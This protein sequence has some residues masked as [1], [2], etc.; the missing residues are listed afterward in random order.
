MS[1]ATNVGNALI[2]SSGSAGVI[3]TINAN[4]TVISIGIAATGVLM[5]LVFH[6]WAVVDRK[7]AAKRDTTKQDK[8][9]ELEQQ[10]RNAKRD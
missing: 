8:I 10:L 3:A 2:I 4:A 9:N 6:I 7:L 5:G 1:N